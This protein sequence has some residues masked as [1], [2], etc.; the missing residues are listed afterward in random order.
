M[1]FPRAA[2]AALLACA[3]TACSDGALPTAAPAGPTP[4][5]AFSL[6]G[7]T[8]AVLQIASA[9][10]PAQCL[11]VV[12]ISRTPGARTQLWTCSGGLNQQWTW[13]SD[14]TIR[15]YGGTMCLDVA[16]GQAVNGAAAVIATCT[17]QASQQWTA[18]AA[19]EIRGFSGM[20]LDIP[21]GN[22]A[23]GSLLQIWACSGN[24]SNLNQHWTNSPASAIVAAPPPT[25]VGVAVYP[26]Q[27]IQAAVNANPTGTTFILKSGT[28][29]RQSVVPKAGD[30]FHGETGTVLDGQG[31][32]QWA[33]RG[34]NGTAWV[35]HVTIRAVKITNYTPPF[36]DGA[37]SGGNAPGNSTVGWVV[38]SNEVSYST[39][40]GI[41]IG[42]SMQVTNNY[43]H[44]NTVSNVSGTANYVLVQN[45]EIAWGNYARTGDN[46]F[47]SGGTKFTGTNG[48]VLRGNYVH[49][50]QGVGLWTD[51]DNINVLMENNR[52]DHN[53]GEGILHEVSYA[54]TIR[55]NTI[56]NNGWTD[57]LGNRWLWNAGIV[58]SAS[59]NV[60]LYGNVVS[61]NLNGITG[62]QQ[63]RGSG[64]YGPHLIQNF[65]AHDNTITQ[66]TPQGAGYADAAAGL[67]EDTGDTG[68]FTSRNNRYVHNT[69]YLHRIA[70][71]VA[72]GFEW[73]GWQTDAQW[74]ALGQDTNGTFYRNAP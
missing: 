9:T 60:E 2:A 29:T 66:T 56:T 1:Q 38:D 61:G 37:V 57:P 16:G 33:F 48:L 68:L 41:R 62:V 4:A 26:G 51:L 40:F 22:T 70:A 23:N 13:Q 67:V 59:P 72:P 58:I 17:G 35:N 54:A 25:L 15:V 71:G 34:W 30:V 52:I 11:D 19:G 65:Y 45:N 36:Q 46:N 3:A 53:A 31:A 63:N 50:N 55:N 14:N 27:S 49:D 64:A 42:D 12:N 5:P 10:A 20:C 8:G 21:S 43:V 18:S 24:G 39:Y 47:E 69:Y 28:H 74:R 6:T 73:Q 7:G 44:H 32:T